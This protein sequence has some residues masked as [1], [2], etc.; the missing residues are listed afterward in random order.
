MGTAALEMQ[1]EGAGAAHELAELGIDGGEFAEGEVGV[2]ANSGASIDM[3]DR[4]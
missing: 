4:V 3:R 2:I 1:S